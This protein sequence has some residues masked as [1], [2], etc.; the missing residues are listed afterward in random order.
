MVLIMSAV[1]WQAAFLG[2]IGVVFCFSS[3]L[4]G[5]IISVLL[6]ATQVLAVLFFKESFKAEKGV[7]LLLSLWG[8]VSYFFGE[9]KHS[10]KHAN[11]TD[12]ARI[13]ASTDRDTV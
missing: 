3:L 6:P 9:F 12:I 4:S 8:F 5:V 1:I 2:I 7:S 13:Q 11:Q 10:K